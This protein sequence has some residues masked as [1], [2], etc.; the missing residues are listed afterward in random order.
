M[1]STRFVEMNNNPRCR[2]CSG[3]A[4][5][6]MAGWQH[7][8]HWNWRIPMKIVIAPDSFKDSL[9]RSRRGRRHCPGFGRGLARCA[10]DQMPDGRRRGRDCRVGSCRVRWR[11]APH[12]LVRGPLGVA[13]VDAAWGWLPHSHTAIIEMAEASGLQLV[14]VERRDACISSTFGTGRIDSCCPGCGCPAGRSW[15][16]AAARPTTPAQAPMQA[17]GVKLL[18]AQGQIAR[19]G[20][21]CALAQ[22]ARVDTERYR[23]A[24]G[25]GAL[26]HRR[27]REQSTVRA[28]RR[29]GAFS[30]RKKARTP[31]Q[32]EQLDRA[33]GHFADHCAS[34]LSKDVR[35]PGERRSGRPG[36]CRQGVPRGRSSRPGLKW[37]RRAGGSGRGGCR[38]RSGDHRRRAFRCANIARQDAVWCGAHRSQNAACRSSSSRH[39]GRGLS[40]LVCTWHRR[41]VSP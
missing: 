34:A 37:L 38:C 30:A 31:A 20:R 1:A 24:P 25:R 2:L 33:L 41:R 4:L 18:D 10:T 7:D 26:R 16:S 27:R 6:F 29:L 39:A 22:L 36:V 15:P 17:L 8:G 40:G 35:E 3:P 13:M 19:S 14:P 9:Q 12:R 21:S 28:S 11:T 5:L 23:S 32:V